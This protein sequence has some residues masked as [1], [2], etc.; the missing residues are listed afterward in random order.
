MS[1]CVCVWG[2]GG[3]G[4]LDISIVGVQLKP[5]HSI[6]IYK[7]INPKSIFIQFDM[8]A[9]PYTLHYCISINDFP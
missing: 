9:I 6:Y 3:G 1:V 4:F 5:L 7:K 8:K 2:G